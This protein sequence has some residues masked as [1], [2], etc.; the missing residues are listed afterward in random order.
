LIFEAVGFRQN[1]AM[2]C[3]DADGETGRCFSRHFSATPIWLKASATLKIKAFSNVIG[4]NSH[5]KSCA[6]NTQDDLNILIALLLMFNVI[7]HKYRPNA[8]KRFTGR[9]PQNRFAAGEM[10]VADFRSCETRRRRNGLPLVNLTV[11]VRSNRQPGKLFG[12][13]PAK[14]PH[15]N[16]TMPD[17]PRL[18][19]L[20][21][22]VD[23]AG[24][25]EREPKKAFCDVGT[26]VPVCV[27]VGFQFDGRINGRDEK[28]LCSNVEQSVLK[29]S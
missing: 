28:T 3:F 5:G 22:P 14:L 11:A 13:C 9:Q 12:R 19:K 7:A 4:K 10:A 29:T 23:S 20:S 21:F 8:R 27:R 16:T 26:P 15:R 1:G 24:H 18:N 2:K 6:L 17:C 25:Y